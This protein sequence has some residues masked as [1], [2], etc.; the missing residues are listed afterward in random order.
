MKK[1]IENIEDVFKEAFDGFEA[2]VDPSVWTNIQNTMNAGGTGSIPSV[3]P[4]IAIK[5]V[6]VKIVAGVVLLGAIVGSGYYI[7]NF[8]N[9]TKKEVAIIENF[10]DVEKPFIVNEQVETTE[11]D[12]IKQ[13]ENSDLEL[14]A[15]K[16]VVADNNTFKEKE[17]EFNEEVIGQSVEQGDVDNNEANKEAKTPVI[18]QQKRE[19][20]KKPAKVEV[21]K[22]PVAIIA[23][24]T[25]GEAPLDV[26]FEVKGEAEK[27]FWDFGDG[28]EISNEVNPY[29]LFEKEGS[30][31]VEIVVVNGGDSKLLKKIITVRR[32]ITS[33]IDILQNVITPNFDGLNDIFKVEGKNIKTFNAIIR[34]RNGEKIFEWSSIN[35]Y[36]DGR[37]LSNKEVV[38]GTYFVVVVAEGEDGEKYIK[39]QSI[40]VVK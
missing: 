21:K 5:S 38:P 11:L 39:K 36:W 32:K 10:I 30:Y 13:N 18:Q 2:N 26:K 28:S 33:S 9:S 6:M 20:K 4:S 15:G 8:N 24:V 27:Y 12:L 40:T 22:L 25:E 7:M 31:K 35:G 29:H 17:P 23:S 19:E 34:D 14:K 1:G 3:N 16:E 37:D